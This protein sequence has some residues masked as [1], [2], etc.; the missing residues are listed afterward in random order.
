[1]IDPIEEEKLFVQYCD[2]IGFPEEHRELCRGMI[3]A[4]LNYNIFRLRIEVE[5][6][7]KCYADSMLCDQWK[8]FLEERKK[9]VEE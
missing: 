2:E 6:L 3:K 1:M 4:T 8:K 7:R 5:K 9:L